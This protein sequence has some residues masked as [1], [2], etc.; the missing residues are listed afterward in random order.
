MFD[1]TDQSLV[2]RRVKWNVY[3]INYTGTIVRVIK[4]PDPLSLYRPGDWVVHT[5]GRT[6]SGALVIGS[7]EKLLP[8]QN[9]TP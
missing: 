1:P 2:G 9:E 8:S 4:D 3:G 7:A 6:P 5:D